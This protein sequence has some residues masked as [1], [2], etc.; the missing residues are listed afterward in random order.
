[1]IVHFMGG[2]E[3]VARAMLF[4]LL[5]ALG[6][7][8]AA[9]ANWLTSIV[10][11]AGE[12]GGETAGRA[13][14]HLGPVGKAAA[15][16]KELG[17]AP[18]GAL[19][20][21]ATPEGHWQFVNR[22]GETFTVGT[23]DEMSHV[24]PTLAPDAV[25]SGHGKLTLYV[26]EDSVFANRAA[27]DQIPRDADLYVVTDDGAFPL[28][29]TGKGPG[30][31]LTAR[32]KP[33]LAIDLVDQSL[34]EETAFLLARPLNKSNIRTIAL[35]PGASR[36]LTSAPKLDAETKVP[37]VDQLDPANLDEGL[38]AIRGQTALLTGRV[39]EGGKLVVSPASGSE[40]SLAI[41]ELVESAL[42]KDVNLVVLQSDTNR[43][44][45]GRNWLWQKIEVGGLNE[46]AGATT[47]GDFLDA[48]A[49]RRGGFKLTADRNGTDRVH[50]SA[51]P[52]PASA[53]LTAEAGNAFEDLVSH[54]TGEVITKAVELD[55]RDE[56]AEK[57]RDARLIPGVPTYIQYPYLAGLIA[58]LAGWATARRW[59]MKIMPEKAAAEAGRGAAARLSRLPAD[60]AFLLVFLPLAGMPA[61]LVH[62]VLQ[63]V[64]M[65]VAPFRWI[66]RKFLISKV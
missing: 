17:A 14:S 3:R 61:F 21:H 16:L 55:V 4:A 50:V 60:L 8:S 48:L 37:L 38:R 54:V 40:V 24:L 65:V 64:E 62:S 6:V 41:D 42:R 19:A 34:F 11:E 58:G 53:G 18:K 32:I 31:L 9:R 33:H 35:E 20:A 15:F 5:V 30:L 13:A 7:A 51:I 28:M 2:A 1:L 26:S 59:W 23:T 36:S 56:S 27:L 10:R 44:A 45:G 39:E 63:M 22:D 43:Q 46:A 12:V 29:R 52:D 25:A 49:E 66:W 57:E 47:F